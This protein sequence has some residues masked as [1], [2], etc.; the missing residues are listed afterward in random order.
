MPVCAVFVFR[1]LCVCVRVRVS[2]M[3]FVLRLCISICISLLAR[4]L[5]PVLSGVCVCGVAFQ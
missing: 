2:F 5:I 3:F 4:L 1:H